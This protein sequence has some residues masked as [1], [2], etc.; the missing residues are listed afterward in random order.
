MGFLGLR[1]SENT[2]AGRFWVQLTLLGANRATGGDV[3]NMCSQE[4]VLQSRL[5][6]RDFLPSVQQLGGFPGPRRPPHCQQMNCEK[7]QSRNT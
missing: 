6:L 1:V 3:V 4:L 2:S 7:N 5:V